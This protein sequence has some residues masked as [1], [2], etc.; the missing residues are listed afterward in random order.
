MD[1][2][3]VQLGS[4][5]EAL[6]RAGV[7]AKPTAFAFVYVDSN[8]SVCLARHSS[9]LFANKYPGFPGQTPVFPGDRKRTAEIVGGS[10]LAIGKCVCWAGNEHGLY[11][12]TVVL[13]RAKK[14]FWELHRLPL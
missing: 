12:R 1:P 6:R 13:W 4:Q 5:F 3:S 9:P 14:L 7:D 11:C 10:Y 2:I 8:L